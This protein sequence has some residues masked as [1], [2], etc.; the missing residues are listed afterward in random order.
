[1]ACMCVHLCILLFTCMFLH[2]VMGWES[3]F[4]CICQ[5]NF[6]DLQINASADPTVH[7]LCVFVCTQCNCIYTVSSTQGV[8][9]LLSVGWVCS[10]VQHICVIQYY[11]TKAHCQLAIVG[12]LVGRV[13]VNM[14]QH[15]SQKSGQETYYA[16][17]LTLRAQV[18]QQQT[19]NTFSGLHCAPCTSAS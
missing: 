2:F 12:K 11:G 14:A 5:N 18:S 10:L 9:N 8:W 16:T 6:V 1:L 3:C 4:V 7:G 15:M 19:S 13:P 17:I